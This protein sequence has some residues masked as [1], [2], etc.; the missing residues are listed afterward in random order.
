MSVWLGH[1]FSKAVC[2]NARNQP[3]AT[4]PLVR[5]RVQSI[6]FLRLQSQGTWQLGH[7][8]FLAGSRKQTTACYCLF[9]GQWLGVAC[10]LLAI[11]FFLKGRRFN[12]SLDHALSID[13]HIFACMLT[14][15]PV[16]IFFILVLLCR[17]FSQIE[18]ASTPLVSSD[19][20]RGMCF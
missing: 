4:V 15:P 11:V 17:C 9:S 3:V 18:L 1:W 10:L 2:N 5:N 12:L 6:P 8:S 20:R 16:V 7:S 19:E 13:S 14:Q